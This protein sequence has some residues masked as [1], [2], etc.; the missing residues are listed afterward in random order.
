M[1]APYFVRRF[2]TVHIPRD[3][4]GRVLCECLQVRVTGANMRIGVLVVLAAVVLANLAAAQV[5]TDVLPFFHR[6]LCV[7]KVCQ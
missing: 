7:E 4:I 6:T 3:R 1:L 2:T 5:K